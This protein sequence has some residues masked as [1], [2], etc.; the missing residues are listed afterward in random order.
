METRSVYYHSPLWYQLV[1]Q[2]WVTATVH[3]G[4]A[5]MVKR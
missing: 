3:A 1:E 4:I 2:G 5:V